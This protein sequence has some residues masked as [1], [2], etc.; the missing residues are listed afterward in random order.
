MVVAGADFSVGQVA[1]GRLPRKSLPHLSFC[2]FKFLE[3]R[4]GFHY[5]SRS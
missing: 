2:L 3:V 1:L 4:D 5:F